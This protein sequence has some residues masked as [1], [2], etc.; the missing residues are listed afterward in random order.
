MKSLS[1]RPNYPDTYISELRTIP[2]RIASIPIGIGAP[3]PHCGGGVKENSLYPHIGKLPHQNKDGS[4]P[5]S[6]NRDG[7]FPLCLDL[8]MC[9]FIRSA[10]RVVANL[11]S[12][13]HLI[14]RRYPLSIT[15]MLCHSQW[16]STSKTNIFL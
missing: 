9:T 4:F 16:E 13:L 3:R 11:I 14:V 15:G 8:F 6:P 5:S 7:S 2:L 12:E 1:A 10:D